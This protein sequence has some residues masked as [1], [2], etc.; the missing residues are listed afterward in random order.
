MTGYPVTLLIRTIMCE[1]TRVCAYCFVL[2]W[3]VPSLEYAWLLETR[4]QA[5]PRQRNVIECTSA[6]GRQLVEEK[7]PEKF[8]AKRLMESSW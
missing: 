7:L 1:C 4:A 8:C 6:H 3:Q 2:I 5:K